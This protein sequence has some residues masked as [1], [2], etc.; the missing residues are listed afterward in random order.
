MKSPLPKGFINRINPPF[1]ILVDCSLAQ[2]GKPSPYPD[3]MFSG[4][5]IIKGKRTRVIM[6]R[7]ALAALFENIYLYFDN[8]RFPK[9][10]QA[11]IKFPKRKRR[12]ANERLLSG[13]R[14]WSYHK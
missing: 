8:G 14:N 4:E 10:A 11:H 3:E 2:I 12:T 1:G 13:E 5:V 7:R 6:D 9:E